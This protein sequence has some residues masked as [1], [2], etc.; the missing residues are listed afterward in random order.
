MRA[1]ILQAKEKK[2]EVGL[3]LKFTLGNLVVTR[4]GRI[5]ANNNFANLKERRS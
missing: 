4:D 5:T 1:R 2:N 3:I